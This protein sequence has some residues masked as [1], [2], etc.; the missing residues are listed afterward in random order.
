M[1]TGL[2]GPPHF[3][4]HGFVSKIRLS[5]ILYQ[6]TEQ[7]PILIQSINSKSPKLTTDPSG[8]LLGCQDLT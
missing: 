7:I 5:S 2:Y 1:L 4:S 8:N 3:T 6:N